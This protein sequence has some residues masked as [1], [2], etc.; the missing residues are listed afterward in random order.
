MRRCCGGQL[1]HRRIDY[2]EIDQQIIREFEG[3]HPEIIQPWLPNG[4]GLF[5]ADPDHK[6]T[7]REKKHR[8]MLLLE[9]WFGLELSKKHFI[10][11]KP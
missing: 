3:S 2:R 10:E 11:I 7:S 1:R 5:R 4:E 9:R 8:L 6:L